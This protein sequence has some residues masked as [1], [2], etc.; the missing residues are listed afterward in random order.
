MATDAEN[1]PPIVAILTIVNILVAVLI[2]IY[3]IG[4]Q[5]AFYAALFATPVILVYLVMLG[6]QGGDPRR[7]IPSDDELADSE[8]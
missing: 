8:G 1:K 7:A 4:I 2:G 6:I 3:F 5:V